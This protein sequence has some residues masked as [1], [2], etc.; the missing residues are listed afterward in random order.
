MRSLRGAKGEPLE[1]LDVKAG[2][3]LRLETFDDGP[4]EL[5]ELSGEGNALVESWLSYAPHDR[6]LY[7]RASLLSSRIAARPGLLHGAWRGHAADP[8]YGWFALESAAL[9]WAESPLGSPF[10][11]L[12]EGA[13][14]D[15]E[16]FR[17]LDLELQRALAHSQSSERDRASALELR[18]VMALRAVRELRPLNGLPYFNFDEPP[19]TQMQP[20]HDEQTGRDVYRLTP[21]KPVT[22]TLDGPGIFELLGTANGTMKQ[23]VRVEVLEGNLPRGALSASPRAPRGIALNDARRHLP[24]LRLHLPPGKHTY[25][26]RASHS[27]MARVLV[28]RPVVHVEDAHLKSERASLE[29]AAKACEPPLSLELCAVYRELAGQSGEPPP[30]TKAEKPVRDALRETAWSVV[31]GGERSWYASLS[32]S[33]EPACSDE[34]TPS[35]WHEVGAAS[36]QLQ[37]QNWHG[38]PALE[39]VVASSCDAEPVELEVDGQALRGAPASGLRIWHI[40]VRGDS[41]QVRRLDHGS[42]RVY[43]SRQTENR[44]TR[45]F[46]RIRA[47]ELA[48]D[49][50]SLDFGPDAIAPGVELWLRDGTLS[51][52]LRITPRATQTGGKTLRLVA[53]AAPGFSALDDD[54]ARWVRVTRVAL[55]TWARSGVRVEG[56]PG[57]AVRPLVRTE[58]QETRAAPKPTAGAL[59]PEAPDVVLLTALSAKLLQAGPTERAALYL[60]RALLL[61]RAGQARGAL[62]D[63]RAAAALGATGNEGSSALDLVRKAI[64]VRPNVP[65][66]L[67]SDVAAFGVEPDF[68]ADA[69]PCSS[70]TGVRARFE[71]VL[72][73]Q[74][75]NDRAFDSARAATALRAVEDDLLDP[76]APPLRIRAVARSRYREVKSATSASPRRRFDEPAS[77]QPEDA[78]DAWGELRPAIASGGAFAE[79]SYAVVDAEHPARARLTGLRPGEKA[80]IELLCYAREPAITEPC[81]PTIDFEGPSDHQTQLPPGLQ[82]VELSISRPHGSLLE[83]TLPRSP[84]RFVLLAR[85]VVDRRIT[86]TSELAGVGFVLAPRPHEYRFELDPTRPFSL[87]AEAPRIVRL[88]AYA[89]SDTE[90][91]A[92]VGDRSW[93]LP[94]DGTATQLVLEAGES[95]DVRATKGAVSLAVS[96][97]VPDDHAEPLAREPTPLAE[98]APAPRASSTPLRYDDGDGTSVWQREAARSPRPLTRLEDSLG[99]A[100][101]TS[102]AVVGNG[103]N[104]GVV[105]EGASAYGFASL[106]YRRRIES[107]GLWTNAAAFTRVRAGEPTY[108]AEGSLYWDLAEAHTR[109][110]TTGSY[111]TQ[112]VAGIPARALRWRGFAEYS[113][114]ATSS[115]FVLPRL[116]W[117]TVNVS[118]HFRPS[119]LLAVDD[120]IYDPYRARRPTFV[121]GQALFWLA[122]YFDDIFYL[123]V[124]GTHN[125]TAGKFSH[126]SA[127]PGAFTVFGSLDLSAF[128]DV[129]WY[130]ASDTRSG[131]P[132]MQQT[133][134][135]GAVYD[136]WFGHGSLDIAPGV[137]TLYR[138]TDGTYQIVASL[139]ILGSFRRGLRDF[140]SLELD[141]PEQRSDGV[142]WRGPTRSAP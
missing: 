33:N 69:R 113:Y 11:E 46:E 130:S 30:L 102:G 16:R 120:E 47:P 36:Q 139:T 142:P 119:S 74:N 21:E 66:P 118:L 92:K 59:A 55:P 48:A 90:A 12:S 53:A 75:Q 60:Q 121:F 140:S 87:A 95:L 124:R 134:N 28:A 84:A 38:A 67:P 103:R 37:T 96:E 61:A 25:T 1:A 116:G 131:T 20:V 108:G 23:P 109:L 13:R 41:A 127:R 123:R 85:V 57:L 32:E 107:I 4:I 44:C 111:E 104:N 52:E 34:S 5:A 7:V 3:V 133:L 99:T 9:R 117:D 98:R 72:D 100:V 27:V 126:A 82:R 91:I 137:S 29:V 6:I 64:R 19:A 56:A 93:R 83:L 78:T 43:A 97:R 73:E 70:S 138:P 14:I 128:V 89:G 114:R 76:R 17:Q 45:R 50:P 71:H 80:R 63:A 135:A 58:R 81:A 18:R 136:F 24:H 42:A 62:A 86:G 8:G 141:F 125:A 122:P 15:V 31:A 40:R 49:N 79:G 106:R 68:D 110:S 115:F 10:P 77:Q 132:Q 22:F 88:R 39:L 105:G 35:A 54:G 94:G 51:G 2:E 112:R 129:T 65:A 26:L 101:L